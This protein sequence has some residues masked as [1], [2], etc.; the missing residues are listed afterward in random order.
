MNARNLRS[1]STGPRLWPGFLVGIFGKYEQIIAV[2]YRSQPKRNSR[3]NRNCHQP[4][5]QRQR[6]EL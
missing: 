4:P 2:N 5:K 6:L 1:P 3:R